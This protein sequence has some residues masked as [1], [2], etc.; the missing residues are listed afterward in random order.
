M[1]ETTL[2]QYP[3]TLGFIPSGTQGIFSTLRKMSVIVRESRKNPAVIAHARNIV[4]HVA[5]KDFY[6]EIVCVQ[7]WIVN[8]IRYTRD[9]NFVETLQYPDV[10]IENGH[11]DCD[12]QSVLCASLL[13][14]IGFRTR[15]C[16]VGFSPN[17]YSHV[18]CEAQV[19]GEWLSVETTENVL[20]GWMPVARYKVYQNVD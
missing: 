13:E 4:A 5:P 20:P 7:Q 6:G 18:F 15:F 14:S 12:D 2:N 3:A 19:G 10:T 9:P 1:Y 11:G 17:V 8:N 16:A